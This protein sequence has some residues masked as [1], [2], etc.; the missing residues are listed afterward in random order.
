[1]FAILVKEIQSYLS[2]LIAYIVIGVFLTSVGLLMWVFPETNVLDYGFA[3]METLFSLAP[4]IFMFL[5]PAITMRTFAEESKAG[6]MELLLTRPL[7]DLQ[8]I[9]G[10][11]VA[12]VLLVAFALLPT[13]LYYYT[14]YQLGN[15]V[16]N[17][18]TAGVIG[19]YIGLL[20]LGAVFTAIGVF[21][22]SITE[23]QIVAFIIAVFMCFLLYTGFSSLSAI[24][25]WGNFAIAIEQMGILYHYNFMSKGLI[26]S[27]NLVYFF[28]V[29]ALMLLCTKMV[30]GSRRW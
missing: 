5:I 15:P 29:I 13:L 21:A 14:I 26:D 4:Y 17:I 23:N 3:D 8:I 2:S 24:P 6:T 30:I 28:S 19:S 11:Y 12:G 10:K 1:M 27:R 9:L 16:G 18:D 20:L 7:T 22:S 25:A